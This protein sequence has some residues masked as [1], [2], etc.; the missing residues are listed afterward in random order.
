MNRT[1]TAPKHDCCQHCLAPH[2]SFCED[3]T[4]HEDLHCVTLSR[5]K[6]GAVKIHARKATWH[7]NTGRLSLLQWSFIPKAMH[8][9]FRQD[10]PSSSLHLIRWQFNAAFRP[11]SHKAEE[12]GQL[13]RALLAPVV[14]SQLGKDGDDGNGH[15]DAECIQQALRPVRGL[16]AQV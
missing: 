9:V 13:A 1:S 11:S 6:L 4:W 5:P 15:E 8:S 16:G 10:Y 2:L 12:G 3:F 14:P 7:E